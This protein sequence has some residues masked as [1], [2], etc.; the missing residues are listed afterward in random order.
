MK[1]AAINLGKKEKQKFEFTPLRLRRMDNGALEVAPASI[2]P[3]E[4]RLPQTVEARL[5]T[6]KIAAKDIN[7]DAP[8]PVALTEGAIKLTSRKAASKLDELNFDPIVKMVALHNQ[9]EADILSMMY[10]D[11]GN[12]RARYSQVAL[13]SLMQ[14]KQKI[15]ADLIRYKYARVPETGVTGTGS[16]LPMMIGMT[17]SMD[18]FKQASKTLI[19]I[20]VN[21]TPMKGSD[22]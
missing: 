6:D 2:E 5:D 14:T 12:P 13:A 15:M 21:D 19:T 3:I 20:G 1:I 22:E 11:I 9:I 4:I 17:T 7:K 18:E 10:D 16:T 8:P